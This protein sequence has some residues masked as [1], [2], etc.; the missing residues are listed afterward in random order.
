MI[1]AEALVKRYGSTPALDGISFEI[2][3]GE[4]VGLLGPNGAGKSTTMRILTGFIRPT[5]GTARVDGHD[6]LSDSLAA[7]RRIGYLPEGVPLYDDMRVTEYLAYRARIKGVPRP[8]RRRRLD[9]AVMR[10]GLTDVRR[11]LIG[12]LSKGYRQRVGIADALIADPPALVLDEPTIGLDPNQ[13]RE[14]RS[15]IRELGESHTVVLSTHILP[16]VEAVCRRV[17]II[18]RGRIACQ[19]SLSGPR[20][21]HVTLELAAPPEGTGNILGAI[22]GVT[23]VA[24]H[25]EGDSVRF[26]MTVAPGSDVRD[27]ISRCA[28]AKGWT[29]RE[30]RRRA[31]SLEDI[32]VRLTV[33][34]D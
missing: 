2:Q 32:F 27:D 6:V 10:C 30:L 13:V 28:A 14:V 33:G 11:R 31:P 25:R 20:E 4:I 22:P 7:R 3:R 9:E 1:Q 23:A 12:A 18:H 34:E 16:E 15:L 5:S 19:E 24:L 29:I 26:E 8:M 21:T 17:I